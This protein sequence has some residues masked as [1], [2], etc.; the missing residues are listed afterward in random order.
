MLA[1]QIHPRPFFPKQLAEG[2]LVR[3][4]ALMGIEYFNCISIFP[5]LIETAA[6]QH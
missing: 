3:L 1:H 2:V 5:G 6:C 4:A